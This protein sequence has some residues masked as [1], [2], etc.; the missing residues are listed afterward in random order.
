VKRDRFR[1]AKYQKHL[2]QKGLLNEKK[3]KYQKIIT[4]DFFYFI[5]NDFFY[6]VT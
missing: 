2:L 4:F 5:S 6:Y 1:W 3:A